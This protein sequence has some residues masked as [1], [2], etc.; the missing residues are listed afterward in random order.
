[1]YK[2]ILFYMALAGAVCRITALVLLTALHQIHLPWL[3]L[4]LSVLVAVLGVA[5]VVKR[6]VREVS[7]WQLAGYHILA[8]VVTILNFILLS[9]SPIDVS[10]IET[11]ITGSVLSVLASV[12]VLVLAFRRKRY[13]TV[14]QR[15]LLAL[16]TR[17]E[18]E[19]GESAQ[20][21]AEPA[22]TAQANASEME[23]I[24]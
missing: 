1:M 2:Q 20:P 6:L 17:R 13:I 3:V 24:R 21:E 23:N 16:E 10:M 14:R 8:D 5:V 12:T 22:A 4:T 7:I 19:P 11:A 15:R 9:F 18:S